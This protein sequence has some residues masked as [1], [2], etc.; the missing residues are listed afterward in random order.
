MQPGDRIRVHSEEIVH[1]R[2]RGDVVELRPDGLL[3][4]IDEPAQPVFLSSEFIT[5]IERETGRR[6]A[7]LDGAFLG[8]LTGLIT[9]I[10]IIAA[11]E[12]DDRIDP[13]C[14]ELHC[15]GAGMYL[16]S[17]AVGAAAGALLGSRFTISLWERVRF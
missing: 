8:A 14:G 3:L 9:G 12:A 17:T 10:A 13:V 1:F 11:A 5:R 16:T 6:R 7:T 15:Y 2:T 4:R